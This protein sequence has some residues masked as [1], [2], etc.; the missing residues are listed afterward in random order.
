VNAEK[1]IYSSFDQLGV[2][3]LWLKSMGQHNFK[4]NHYIF[5]DNINDYG[6]IYLVDTLTRKTIFET[7][8]DTI[9]AFDSAVGDLAI[10]TLE[11]KVLGYSKRKLLSGKIELKL[12]NGFKAQ[13]QSNFFSSDYFGIDEDKA[14]LLKI[15]ASSTI[16]IT[17][18]KPAKDIP[19]LNVLILVGS[20]AIFGS[21]DPGDY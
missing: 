20:K 18:I 3:T 16:A 6:C 13:L 9:V 7:Y 11:K 17:F 5:T 4:Y 10:Q 2:N 15:T 19:N 21:D 12:N 8:D 14:E 1:P